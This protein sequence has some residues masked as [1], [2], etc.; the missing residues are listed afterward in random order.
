MKSLSLVETIGKGTLLALLLLLRRA[1]RAAHGAVP[2]PVRLDVTWNESTWCVLRQS[3]L[4]RHCLG[5]QSASHAS[6]RHVNRI[7]SFFSASQFGLRLNVTVTLPSTPPSRRQAYP[8]RR[9]CAAPAVWICSIQLVQLL[10]CIHLQQRVRPCGRPYRA[11][12]MGTPD[13]GMHT[14]MQ[15]L[16]V[17]R[18]WP[19]QCGQPHQLRL[20]L[21]RSLRLELPLQ[22]WCRIVRPMLSLLGGQVL[23]TGRALSYPLKLAP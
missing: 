9:G 19:G 11:L 3:L 16:L 12:L 1:A 10:Q 14:P 17:E 6:H 15:V 18:E 4:Q 8:A 23:L 21:L 20:L 2:V 5:L 22:Q 13:S 7:R